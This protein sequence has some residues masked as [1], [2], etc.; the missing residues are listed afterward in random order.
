MISCIVLVHVYR[1]I[2]IRKRM[3]LKESRSNTCV[4]RRGHKLFNLLQEFLSIISNLYEQNI[5]KQINYT[6]K[7]L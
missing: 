1:L 3:E 2:I 4:Q 5:P 6:I 7:T